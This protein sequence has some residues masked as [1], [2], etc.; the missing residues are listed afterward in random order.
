MRILALVPSVYDTSPGQRF[1]IE[2]W[3]PI[4]AQD[5]IEIQ[6]EPF[7]SPELRGLLYAPGRLARKMRL[8]AAAFRRRVAVLR[9]LREY[10]LVYIFREAA[11]LGPAVFE[12]W[13]HR[14]RV[15][16]VFDFD[17]AV[18][19]RYVSPANSYLS[20]LKFPG[21]TRG[22]CR[23]AAHVMAGNGHLAEYARHVSPNVTIVPTTIDTD[24]YTVM[25][26][27][28]VEGPPPILGWSGSF[29][30]IQ[31]L[32]ALRGVLARLAR[33]HRF[34]L[35]VIGAP[36]YAI[37]GVDVEAVPWCSATEVE[38]LR[39]I[40]IGLMPLPDDPW[41]RGKC[42]LKALQYMALGI[43]TVCSPVGVNSEIIQEGV[44]GLLAATDET[45]LETLGRLMASPPLRE[46][47]GAAGRRTVEE[48]YSARVQ[49]PVVARIFASVVR[50]A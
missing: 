38:D 41:S 19:I 28:P 46:R 34:R 43:P 29:S 12:R 47:L 44:N 1:R 30:T 33:A 6:H 5:G 25:P 11:V 15:P 17:D 40:D 35:R 31:H 36:H 32:D 13:V 20:Y 22:I 8:V 9:R 14:S 16:Y 26:R 21:K 49:A 4:L 48:R 24:R 7:E 39:P 10:D 37:D 27:T 50:R 42:G 18:F 23:R 45:W 2:Q 3:A